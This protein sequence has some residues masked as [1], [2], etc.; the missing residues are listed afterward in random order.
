MINK[1]F[2]IIILSVFLGSNLSLHA[3][4]QSISNITSLSDKQQII[5]NIKSMWTAVKNNDVDEYMTYIHP[6]YSVFGE[7]DV[8][9]HEGADKER[10]DYADYLSRAKGVSNLYAR[11]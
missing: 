5:D 10:I 2:K 11:P 4:E 7:G 6:N 3:E 1:L 8:Y 9:L